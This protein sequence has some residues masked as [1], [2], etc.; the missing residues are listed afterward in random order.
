MLP[1]SGA[2]E[3]DY[4]EEVRKR[5]LF[6]EIFMSSLFFHT[7]IA[8]SFDSLPNDLSRKSDNGR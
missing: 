1:T 4:R 8:L 5:K 3:A 2:S 6:F 7:Y